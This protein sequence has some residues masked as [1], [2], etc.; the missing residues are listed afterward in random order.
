MLVVLFFRSG[1]M[2]TREF[3][4]DKLIGKFSKKPLEKG[5]SR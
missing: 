1:I 3:T 4:W 2:G 5:G